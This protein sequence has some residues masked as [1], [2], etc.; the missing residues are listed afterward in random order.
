M[1]AESPVAER[2]AVVMVNYHGE[3]HLSASLAALARQTRP[4]DRIILVDNGS[5]EAALG[6]ILGMYPHIELLRMGSNVG[7]AAANNRAVD[8]ADDC[9]WIALLNVD[10]FP[11][12]DWLAELLHTAAVR[13]DCSFFGSRQ[14]DASERQR[15]DGTGDVYHSSGRVWRRNHGDPAAMEQHATT[16]TATPCA[17]AALY[18]REAWVHVGGLDDTFFCYLEDVDLG[19]RLQLAGYRYAH[20]ARASVRHVGSAIAGRRSDFS[21]Y[22]GQRNLVWTYV[23]NMPGRLFWKY[24]PQHLLLNIFGLFVMIWRGRGRAALRA[25]L[26]AV[27]AMPRLWRCRRRIQQGRRI[28]IAEFDSLLSHGLGGL[29]SGR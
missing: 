3:K 27:K 29:V 1:D 10:A 6:S 19:L 4:A 18:L 2:V 12:E 25:K 28:S 7:F 16:G 8:A 20:V 21:V 26:D 15:L 14:V 17:A 24:L 9:R 22:H 23:K 11:D 13:T 5:D